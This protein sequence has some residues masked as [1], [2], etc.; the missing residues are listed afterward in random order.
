MT[1]GSQGGETG[2][3]S[4]FASLVGRPNVGKSTLVNVMVGG[5]VAIVTDKPQTTR[6]AIRGVLTLEDAQVVFVDTPGLHKPRNLLGEHL[7]RVI[8]RTLG[9]VDVAVGLF[10][11][12]QEVGKGDAFLAGEVLKAPSPAI[13]VLT[14]ADLV[15]PDVLLSR[16][17]AVESLGDWHIVLTTS[18]VRGTGIID[19]VH[20]I[21]GLL[22]GGP[23]FYPQG[24]ITDQPDS[25]VAGEIVR[26]K[27]LEL[28]R[29]EVPHGVAVVVDELVPRED[30]EL[31][32]IHASIYVARESQKGIV[33]GRGGK[34]LKEVG[35]RARRDLEA[36]LGTKVYLDLRVKVEPRWQRDEDLLARMG[37]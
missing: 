14:K 13:G 5:K 21:V 15:T 10:D 16:I 35:S 17:E 1:A 31:V 30:K 11:A 3:R 34:M 18:A 9:E 24:V 33:I 28:T 19:L 7:N 32:D 27:V 25:M 22:P 6:N 37:Y 23:L 29:Q 20:E 26:E 4:G 36:L 12:S 8:R 2:F